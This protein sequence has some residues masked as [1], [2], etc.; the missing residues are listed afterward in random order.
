M[1]VPSPRL[2]ARQGGQAVL[3]ALLVMP[4][5]GLLLLAV[6]HVGSAQFRLLEA[7]EESR[8]AAFSAARGMPAVPGV[9]HVTPAGRGGRHSPPSLAFEQDWLQGPVRWHR[10]VAERALGAWPGGGLLRV[11]RAATVVGGTGHAADDAS[12]QRRVAGSGAGWKQAQS[13]SSAAARALNPVV[14]RM[15]GP[16]GRAP[17]S[18]DW[19]QDWADAM[20]SSRVATAR[21][22]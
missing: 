17:L 1:T 8:H 5:L 9:A 3:E 22:P 12:G 10:A 6:A 11:R 15:D 14:A 2:A 16:W 18:L 20:P 13:A 4:L 7:G 21:R 19:V